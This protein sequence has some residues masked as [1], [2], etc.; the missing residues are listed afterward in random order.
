MASIAPSDMYLKDM[1]PGPYNP[2]MSIPTD[3]WDS[4]KIG[5]GNNN[6]IARFVPGTKIIGMNEVTISRG[7]SA[8]MQTG[9]YTMIY[10]KYV[11]Y[12]DAQDLSATDIVVMGCGSAKGTG[13]MSCSRDMSAGNG[14]VTGGPAAIACADCTPDSYVWAWC[15]G[16]APLNDC[17][18]LDVTGIVTDGSVEG[19]EAFV[20]SVGA[21]HATF[22]AVDSSN[23]W[24]IGLALRD[25][26]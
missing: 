18:A 17:T 11:C 2:H 7:R 24:P 14:I 25:D 22:S 9:G 3:G 20:L 6:S 12:T 8:T 19:G 10:T 23:N 15:G 16:Q 13:V 4:T 21:S 5:A 1:W 26:T